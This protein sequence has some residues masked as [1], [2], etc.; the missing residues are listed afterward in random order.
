MRAWRNPEDHVIAIGTGAVLAHA[1][2]TLLGAEVLL[3]AKVDERVEVFDA[4]GPY[5]AAATAIAAIGTAKLD[6]FLAPEADAAVAAI[7][8]LHINFDNIEELHAA[9][10]QNLAIIGRRNS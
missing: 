5:V 3:I 7:A 1:V 2:A 9:R 10:L 4:L 6:K 8:R